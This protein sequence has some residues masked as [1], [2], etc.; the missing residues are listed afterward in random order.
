MASTPP[1]TGI[2]QGA[3]VYDG[4]RLAI[5]DYFVLYL[6]STWIWRCSTSKVTLPLFWRN[7]SKRHLDIGVGTG[8]FT[9]NGEL[10]PGAELTL[11]DL[12]MNCLEMAK[13]R[14]GRPDVKCNILYHD[15]FDPLP[16]TASPFDSISMFYLL[17]CLPG[18]CSRKAAIFSHLKHSMTP[19][20]VIFGANV[21][22]ER[23]FHTRLSWWCV[24]RINRKKIMDN[25][26]DNEK[27]FTMALRKNFHE[28]ETQ[29]NGAVFVFKA[30]RPIL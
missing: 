5:Y 13:A 23:R 10:P 12:N 22:G 29:V 4:F 20:G 7:V 27:E 17:H 2:K 24:N 21:L 14:L 19:D 6:M 3:H 9:T 11:S 30:R 25:L 1:G 26:G 18:P 16:D 28:V 8:Y 15:V